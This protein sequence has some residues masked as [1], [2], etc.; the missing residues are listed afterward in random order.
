MQCHLQFLNI[1]NDIFKV[2]VPQTKFYYN[3]EEHGVVHNPRRWW[4]IV[5]EIIRQGYDHKKR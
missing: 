3:C 2:V 5:V 1:I 4:Q